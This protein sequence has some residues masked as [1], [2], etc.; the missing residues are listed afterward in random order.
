MFTTSDRITEFPGGVV[1][2]GEFFAVGEVLGR[3]SNGEGEGPQAR[4]R[5]R[6]NG[7]SPFARPEGGRPAARFLRFAGG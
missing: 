2:S 3:E 7:R 1:L 6:R 5:S 4:R